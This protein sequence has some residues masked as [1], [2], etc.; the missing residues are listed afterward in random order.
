[1]EP[2]HIKNLIRPF[3][4]KI[5][6]KCN[7]YRRSKGLPLLPTVEEIKKRRLDTPPY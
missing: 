6:I 3:V 7:D 1:M 4:E 5:R 2:K